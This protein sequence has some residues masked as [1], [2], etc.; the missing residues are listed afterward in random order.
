MSGSKGGILNYWSPEGLL[1]SRVR[2]SAPVYKLH[3]SDGGKR[4]YAAF[5]D[6]HVEICAGKHLIKS[7]PAHRTNVISVSANPDGVSFVTTAEDRFVKL[8]KNNGELLMTIKD[9]K[10]AVTTA[11]Y[12]PGKMLFATGGRDNLIKIFHRNGLLF[13]TLKGHRSYIWCIRFTP[14]GKYLVSA[15]RTGHCEF[16]IQR[17]GRLSVFIAGTAVRSGLW[18]YRETANILSAAER[19]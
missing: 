16:G 8:W 19:R 4:F 5:G 18:R 9:H 14:D 17:A 6:G 15:S 2:R 7:I 12:H 11:A 10:Q 3:S 13:K 1:L